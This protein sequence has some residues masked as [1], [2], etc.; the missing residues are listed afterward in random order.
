MVE[1]GGTKGGLDLSFEN[2]KT[3]GKAGVPHAFLICLLYN[4][5]FGSLGIAVVESWIWGE[6]AYATHTKSGTLPR[7]HSF[8]A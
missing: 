3:L 8:A 2:V 5:S 7:T 1:N 6:L 4:T